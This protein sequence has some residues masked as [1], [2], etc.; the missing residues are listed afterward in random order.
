MGVHDNQKVEAGTLIAQIDDADYTAKVAAA[1]A[2]LDAAI[3]QAASADAQVDITKST[4]GGALS[5]ARAMLVGQGASV[6]SAAA[7]ADAAQAQ[8]ARSRA[9]LIEAQSNLDRAKKLHDAGAVSGQA[10]ET[11]Q[12]ARGDFGAGHARWR[13]RATLAGARDA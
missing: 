2:D 5:S 10:L 4:S 12:A 9:E 7:Q 11:A 6:R 13:E 8:I 1:R 3:A